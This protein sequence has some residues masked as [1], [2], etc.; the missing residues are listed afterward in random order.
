MAQRNALPPCNKL[1]KEVPSAR[2]KTKRLSA[3]LQVLSDEQVNGPNG[4]HL[5]NSNGAL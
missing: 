3:L 1:M 2:V 5:T 4:V